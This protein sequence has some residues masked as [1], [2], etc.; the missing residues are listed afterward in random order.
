MS[1]LAA[2]NRVVSL[3]SAANDFLAYAKALLLGN[4]TMTQ[5]LE[6]VQHHQVLGRPRVVEIIKSA[7]AAGATA[8]AVAT[9]QVAFDKAFLEVKRYLDASFAQ[10]EQRLLML[11]AKQNGLKYCGVWHEGNQYKP[12]NMTTYSG[13]LWHCEQRTASKPGT[14]ATWKLCVKSRTFK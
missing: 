11:E 14:D 3:S 2:L 10:F 5:T 9:L 8:D 4:G 12:G 7:I 6:A 1:D 13:S